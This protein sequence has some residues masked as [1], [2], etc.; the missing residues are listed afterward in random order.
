MGRPCED[1]TTWL[2][3]TQRFAQRQ[4][5]G[6]LACPPAWDWAK[7]LR[8]VRGLGLP[9]GPTCL[10]LA[11]RCP[12]IPRSGPLCLLLHLME[13]GGPSPCF[14]RLSDHPEAFPPCCA[15]YCVLVGG[16]VVAWSGDCSLGLAPSF[17]GWCEG[18]LPGASRATSCIPGP[19]PACCLEASV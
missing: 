9:Q 1:L 13:D 19:H 6:A 18:Q 16:W 17:R 2:G 15:Q 3:V 10:S 11:E 12:L 5:W 7:W 8:G 14:P 4:A